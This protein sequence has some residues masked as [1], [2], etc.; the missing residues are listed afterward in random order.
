M[1]ALV[2]RRSRCFGSTIT[3]YRWPGGTFSV[4]LPERRD[5]GPKKAL[6]DVPV[7]PPS[8]NARCFFAHVHRPKKVLLWLPPVGQDDESLFLASGGVL[9]RRELV[10]VSVGFDS[11]RG[12][13]V[14]YDPAAFED[15]RTRLPEAVLAQANVDLKHCGIAGAIEGYSFGEKCSNG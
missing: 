12:P 9:A 10:I 3:K 2:L 7:R 13:G 6:A 14:G 11:A 5:V 8:S 4:F 1:A 15:L